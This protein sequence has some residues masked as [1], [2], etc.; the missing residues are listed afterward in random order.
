MDSTATME[1]RIAPKRIGTEQRAFPEWRFLLDSA[2]IRRDESCEAAEISAT[3]DWPLLL[4][5]AL[6]HGVLGLLADRLRAARE[7]E[8][9]VAVLSELNAARRDFAA[10]SLQLTAELFRILECF[11]SR[12]VEL[13][14]TKGPALSLRCYGNPGIRRYADLDLIVRDRD[15]H[16]ATEIMQG[17]GYQAKIPLSEIG[18]ASCR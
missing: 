17:L 15:I 7:H 11:R 14:L 10:H 4:R 8:I 3:L 16:G 6:Q 18:R 5:L 12:S 2:A 13:L 1:P 9:P